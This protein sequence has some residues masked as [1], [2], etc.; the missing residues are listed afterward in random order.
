MGTARYVPPERHLGGAI[1]EVLG[2]V[3]SL[4]CLLWDMLGGTERPRLDT[5]DAIPAALAAVVAR[6]VNHDPEERF[7]STSAMAQR[8]ARRSIRPPRRPPQPIPARSGV[9][10]CEDD[11]SRIEP[12]DRRRP[13]E[14]APLSSGLVTARRSSSATRWSRWGSSKARP[15]P[16]STSRSQPPRRA[17]AN[18]RST[19]RAGSG[20]STLVGALI[21]RRLDDGRGYSDLACDRR[22]RPW[23]ARAGHRSDGCRWPRRGRPDGGGASAR[24]GARA[25]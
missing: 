18:S 20:R 7:G 24:V 21:G 22:R 25:G 4:G 10:R 9:G 2:D 15:S 16:S 14:P 3:Y 1:D 19:A 12:P 23:R 17:A 6:A 11:R 8:R 13:F 5:V